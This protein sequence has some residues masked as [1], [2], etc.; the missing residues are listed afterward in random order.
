MNR[1]ELIQ[2]LTSQSKHIDAAEA[3]SVLK[4]LQNAE[5]EVKLALINMISKPVS[6]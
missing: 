6:K 2:W 3:S 1:I 4:A 5:P